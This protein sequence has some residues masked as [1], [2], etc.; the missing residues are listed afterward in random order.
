MEDMC[1][2][3]GPSASPRGQRSA[4]VPLGVGG[5]SGGGFWLLREGAEGNT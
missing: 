5:R 2:D 4:L 1:G 3:D